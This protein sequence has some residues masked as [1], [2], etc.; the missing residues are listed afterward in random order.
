MTWRI[1][2]QPIDYVEL[3]NCTMTEAPHVTDGVKEI[4]LVDC[5]AAAKRFPETLI[6]GED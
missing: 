1:P 3:D 6:R 2:A 5:I 4:V